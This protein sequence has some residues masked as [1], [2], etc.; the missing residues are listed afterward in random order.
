M[1]QLVLGHGLDPQHLTHAAVDHRRTHMCA[2]TG[3]AWLHPLLSCRPLAA[4]LHLTRW[5]E[6]GLGPAEMT[7]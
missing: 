5:A 3:P 2:R 1:L 6:Q 7:I 4:L